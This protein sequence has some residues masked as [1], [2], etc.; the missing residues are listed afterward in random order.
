MNNNNNGIII[1]S[2]YSAHL[3]DGMRAGATSTHSFARVR[4]MGG[5]TLRRLRRTSTESRR[6][7]CEG[8][9][10]E[11]AGAGLG[12]VLVRGGT[13]SPVPLLNP[14]P[15]LIAVLLLRHM[16]LLRLCARVPVLPCA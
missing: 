12:K 7:R 14:V 4:S 1:N 13:G 2:M 11:G 16:L 3:V 9:R 10:Q 6:M 15:L 8:G 5:R